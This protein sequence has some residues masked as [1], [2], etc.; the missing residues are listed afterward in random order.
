MCECVGLCVIE[1]SVKHVSVRACLL[2]V[3]V[4]FS[5]S[6]FSHLVFS[7]RLHRM[8]V[9]LKSNATAKA[10]PSP[11]PTRGEAGSAPLTTSLNPYAARLPKPVATGDYDN[12]AELVQHWRN[13]QRVVNRMLD[14]WPL[15]HEGPCHC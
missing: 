11:S 9:K 7:V 14:H 13:G 8:P 3:C 2:H 5:C 15:C 4:E 6:S 12:D 10:L 1:L